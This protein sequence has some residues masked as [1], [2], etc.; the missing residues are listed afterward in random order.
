MARN[1]E[2]LE[3]EIAQLSPEQLKEFRAWCEQFDA[4]TWDEE[5][6]KD[7][8]A[9]KLDKF[10]ESAMAAHEA[11]RGRVEQWGPGSTYPGTIIERPPS[12]RHLDGVRFHI[13]D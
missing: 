8:A 10:A 13:A 3:N 9:G 12:P 2:E 5:L 1:V 4:A 6:A 11:G 7:V